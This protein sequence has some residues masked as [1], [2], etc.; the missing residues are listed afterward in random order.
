[1][2]EANTATDTKTKRAKVADRTYI[3]P[4]GDS[5]NASDKATG[6][7]F[8]F[9]DKSTR[10]VDLYKFP[11]N[12]QKCL[13]WHGL[14]QKLGDSFASAKGNVATALENFDA[15]LEVLMGGTF[16]EKGEGVGPAPTMIFE[17][18][19]RAHK[20]A[21]TK[22]KNDEAAIK[23]ML[24]DKAT[25]EGALQDPKIA[26]EYAAIRAERAQAAAQEAA[27]KAKGAEATTL[28]TF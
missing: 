26:A 25:R 7:K 5:R 17:A 8:T 24:K 23:E 27:K 22:P 3:T 12:I 10:T 9:A 14:S 4:D 16:V 15:L 20:K 18:I 1:M 13:G 11:P 19:M 21:G 2:A 6:L 28:G